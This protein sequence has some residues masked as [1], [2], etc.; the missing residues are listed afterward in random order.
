MRKIWN[1]SPK[2]QKDMRDNLTLI[3]SN[4][5]D[6]TANYLEGYLSNAAI[7]VVRYNTD[8]DLGSTEFTYSGQEWIIKWRS[9][10]LRPEAIATI[11]FRRPEPFTPNI[12]GDDFHTLHAADEW[13]EAWEGFLAQVPL[14]KWVNHPSRNFAASHKIDQL[15]KAS[16]LGFRVPD[17]LVTTDE[18]A[19]I[20]FCGRQKNGVIVKPLASGFI[21]RLDSEKDTV[22]YT[23]KLEKEDFFLLHRLRDCPVLF[24][25]EINKQLDIR[26][27]IL[28]EEMIAIG[29]EA[30]DQSG[31][32]RLD[33]RRNNMLGV[34]YTHLAIPDKIH[35][36]I[37]AIMKE[38]ELRFAAFDFAID[39]S[40]S[41]VFF[42]INPNGQ[43][44]WFDLEGETVIAE[45]FLRATK[46]R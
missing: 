46:A 35:N 23:A 7:K 2:K 9:Y 21:E 12:N 44:A 43:W 28:D 1:F 31:A 27:I 5:E 17:S 20:K 38:Y 11:F 19:A 42:E 39:K 22:I 6:A 32:Q 40:G 45:L 4:S 30:T 13:A 18:E 29:M 34:K 16:R 24:Q 36:G 33:I 8:T 15:I 41:W 3:L 10:S 25:E 26:V 14:K 37:C